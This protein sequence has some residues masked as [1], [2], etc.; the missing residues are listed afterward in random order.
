MRFPCEKL[1][2]LLCFQSVDLS[3]ELGYVHRDSGA[4]S[5]R[6]MGGK[7]LADARSNQVSRLLQKWKYGG[8]AALE[9][10]MPV[11]DEALR[12][13]AHYLRHECPD[14]TLDVPAVV[15]DAYMPLVGGGGQFGKSA[16]FFLRQRHN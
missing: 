1:K 8:Q 7:P 15:H 2:K 12:K 3:G 14:H 11:V 13:V 5:G 6:R 4:M 9:A 10:L 16:A